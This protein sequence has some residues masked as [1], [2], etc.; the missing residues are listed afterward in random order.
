[1][2]NYAG[3]AREEPAATC[4]AQG[5]RKSARGSSHTIESAGVENR[6]AGWRNGSGPT[7]HSQQNC[8]GEC[9]CPQVRGAAWAHTIAPTNSR[10]QKHSPARALFIDLCSIIPAALRI[11]HAKWKREKPPHFTTGEPQD[12]VS[13]RFQLCAMALTFGGR[14]TGGG[15]RP[16][17]PPAEGRFR[18]TGSLHA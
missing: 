11:S 9:V 4:G 2:R 6:Q 16:R 1:M 14:I 18:P 7:W 3:G 15:R 10:I 12:R 8:A 5:A 13:R 17:R